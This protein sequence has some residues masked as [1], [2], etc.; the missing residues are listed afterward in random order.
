MATFSSTDNVDEYNFES[1]NKGA[2]IIDVLF[3]TVEGTDCDTT[4][5]II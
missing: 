4:K 5:M 2:E 1:S 3:V